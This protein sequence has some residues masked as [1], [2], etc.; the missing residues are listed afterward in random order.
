MHCESADKGLSQTQ[1]FGATLDWNTVCN[2]AC[3]DGQVLCSDTLLNAAAHDAFLE[4]YRFFKTTLTQ[5]WHVLLVDTSSVGGF[6]G[7]IIK[8]VMP[9]TAI[10][11]I[12]AGGAVAVA[13]NSSFGSLDY[14]V[15]PVGD[16][17]GAGATCDEVFWQPDAGQ[18]AADDPRQTAHCDKGY[19]QPN[20]GHWG[21]LPAQF[22]DGFDAMEVKDGKLFITK[23]FIR[24]RCSDADGNV[25]EGFEYAAGQDVSKVARMAVDRSQFCFDSPSKTWVEKGQDGS[26]CLYDE[27]QRDQ[28][29]IVLRNS[30]RQV[31][32][33]FKLTELRPCC[34]PPGETA[35]HDIGAICGASA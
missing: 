29:I 5:R 20:Q 16:H 31:S 23:D 30:L 15:A 17:H 9:I 24:A 35:W 4:P 11:G 3:A 13:M 25:V 33:Q 14:P 22:D 28:G 2:E 12:G 32:L 18:E 7:S 8:F 26:R 21:A 6:A 10:I 27:A 19:P 34:Q 1:D